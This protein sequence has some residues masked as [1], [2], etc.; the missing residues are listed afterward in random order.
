GRNLA[1]LIQVHQD[2]VNGTVG[3]SVLLPVSYRFEGA[4]HF[5]VS[6]RWTFGNSSDPLITC[7]VNCSAGDGGVPRN[8]S[9]NHFPHR[10]Y[11]G[12]TEI[13]PENGSLLLR[14]LQLS[15]SGVYRVT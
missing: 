3:Q 11:H 12:R 8:C 9:A 6:I 4:P 15:D 10:A 5:P 2:S 13:F 14:H 7:T 1:V